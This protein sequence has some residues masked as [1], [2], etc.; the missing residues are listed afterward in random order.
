MAHSATNTEL[1]L[2]TSVFLLF[3]S[4]ISLIASSN[5][6]ISPTEYDDSSFWSSSFSF[7]WSFITLFIEN[8][9][10]L[11]TLFFHNFNRD[12]F[13]SYLIL[14]FFRIFYLKHQKSVDFFSFP[15]KNQKLNKVISNIHGKNPYTLTFL[16]LVGRA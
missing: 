5:S 1:S 4:N 15:R 7:L 2:F 14:E 8:R 10:F 13:F 16:H 9:R 3:Y 11:F 6:V 12:Y